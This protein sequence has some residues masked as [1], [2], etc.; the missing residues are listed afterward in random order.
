[1]VDLVRSEHRY[2]ERRVCRASGI[3]QSGIQYLPQPCSDE[4]PLRSSIIRLASQYGRY[5]YR[6]ITGLLGQEGWQVSRSPVE[7]ISKLEGL[8]RHG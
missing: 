6:M 5:G 2:S 8:N 4:A 1:V 7:R 3:A